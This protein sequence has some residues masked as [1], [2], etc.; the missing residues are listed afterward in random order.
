MTAAP[1]GMTAEM[2]AALPHAPHGP[3]VCWGIPFEADDA[4]ILADQV[5]AVD[6]APTQARWLVFLHASDIRPMQPGAGGISPDR[7][8]PV[9]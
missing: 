3:C 1:P 7:G 6:V 5:V 2:A 4:L 8:R 9:G